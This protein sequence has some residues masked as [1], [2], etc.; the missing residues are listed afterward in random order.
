MNQKPKK[1]LDQVRDVIRVKHYS[2]KTE[3]VYIHWIRRNILFHQK[4]HPRDMGAPEIE[5]FL[6]Y[7]AVAQKVAASTQNQALSA[8][9][10]L[11]RDVLNVNIPETL[12]IIWA[13]RSRHMPTVLSKNEIAKVIG[14]MS[15][16]QQIMAKLMYGSGIRLNECIQLRVKD[17][18]FDYKQVIVHD[19]KGQQSRR[20]LLPESLIPILVEHLKR[21]KAIHQR[22]LGRGLGYTYLSPALERKYPHANREWVWQYAF[23][24]SIV[25]LHKETGIR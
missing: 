20:T 19:G 18:D 12:N 8:I 1:L 9:L 3:Q 10:F 24:S 11:Y 16:T 22:D 15:G 23:P 6:A 7:L 13:K 4:K 14:L 2:P 17:L 25:S 5:A 21:V